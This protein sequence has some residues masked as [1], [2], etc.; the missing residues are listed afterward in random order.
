MSFHRSIAKGLIACLT[1][2]PAMC[3]A[4]QANAQDQE[5]FTYVSFWTVPPPGSYDLARLFPDGGAMDKFYSELS[6]AEKQMP[7]VIEVFDNL[8]IAENH[9]DFLTWA[10]AYSHK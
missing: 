2:L 7:G 6:E 1:A 4:P 5:H 8:T 9:R 10:T 3:L